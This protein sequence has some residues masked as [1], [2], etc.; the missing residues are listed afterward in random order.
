MPI[1][2][3]ITILSVCYAA[4]LAS[5][6]LMYK[7]RIRETFNEKKERIIK[8]K[9]RYFTALTAEH[10]FSAVV[11]IFGF[12]NE[13]FLSYSKISFVSC[14]FLLWAIIYLGIFFHV[15]HKAEAIIYIALIGT[16]GGLMFWS[17]FTLSSLSV[18]VINIE[19]ETVSAFSTTI[20]ISSL[21][22]EPSIWN[23]EFTPSIGYSTKTGEYFYF[24][25]DED[26]TINRVNIKKEDAEP[27]DYY[28]TYVL[29]T[30]DITTVY[31]SEYRDEYRYKTT[32][33]EKIQLYYNP[34]EVYEVNE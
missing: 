29:K 22:N 13:I 21:K 27:A 31:L 10:L 5:F 19:T 6:I 20:N 1:W 7:K 14:S 33:T 25:I 2:L 12:S 28:H 11:I 16:L 24:E 4:S 3:R 23:D 32:E 17:G 18:E 15:W 34:D 26:G 30:K 9:Y 8:L